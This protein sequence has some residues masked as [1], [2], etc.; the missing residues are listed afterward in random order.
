V[1]H[2]IRWTSRPLP[3]R[4]RTQHFEKKSLIRSV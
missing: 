3:Q 4:A 1:Y 2:Q